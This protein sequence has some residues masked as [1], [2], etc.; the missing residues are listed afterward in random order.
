MKCQSIIVSHL[1][2][3]PV[4]APSDIGG[5]GGTSRELTITWTV[6]VFFISV[7]RSSLKLLKKKNTFKF[8]C[9]ARVCLQPVQS[10][11]HYG[12]NFG[13]IIAFKPHDKRDWLKVT[14]SDPHAHKYVHKDPDIP[15]STR[16]EVK[17]KAFNSQGEGP[18]SLSSFIYSAQDGQCVFTLI[19]MSN[20]CISY[21]NL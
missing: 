3:G 1:S 4:V 12:S 14:V 21:L 9:L 11:Y 13:Y 19:C 17:M 20:I 8:I 2:V 18:F 16:F 6:L 10:Q 7:L 5:G 15:P